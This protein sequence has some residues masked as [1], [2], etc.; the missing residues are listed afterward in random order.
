M[1]GV[2][3]SCNTPYNWYRDK[4]GNEFEVIYDP[5]VGKYMA[6]S[7]KGASRYIE[8]EDIEIVEEEENEE[9]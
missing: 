8:K 1:K 9:E 5:N 2:I 4:I 7:N 3:I 6:L